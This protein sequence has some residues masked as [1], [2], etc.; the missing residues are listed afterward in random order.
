MFQRFSL[1]HRFNN[2]NYVGYQM[3]Y[4]K[5]TD[6]TGTGKFRVTTYLPFIGKIVWDGEKWLRYSDGTYQSQYA[7][8]QDW[9]LYDTQT[10]NCIARPRHI[11][12]ED[13]VVMSLGQEEYWN[14]FENI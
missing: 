7:A 13:W 1:Q 3:Q 9:F 10:G 8:P 4:P 14:P 12:A 6:Y 5:Y 11:V 2:R